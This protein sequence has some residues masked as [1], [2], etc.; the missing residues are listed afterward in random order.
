MYEHRSERPLTRSAFTWRL[1]RHTGVGVLLVAGSLAGGMAGYAYFEGLGA[2]DAFLHSSMLLGGMGLVAPPSTPGGKLFAG[3]YAL[4]ASLVFLAVAGIVL[5]P[6]VHRIL[7][8][9]HWDAER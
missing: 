7:H 9:F 8:R 4:Y 3:A 5:A 2:A 6:L 1:V